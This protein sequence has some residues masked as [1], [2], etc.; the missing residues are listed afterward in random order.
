MRYPAQWD[1]LPLLATRAKYVH[2]HGLCIAPIQS[3]GRREGRLQVVKSAIIHLG[4]VTPISKKENEKNE[5]DRAREGNRG[6]ACDLVE[7]SKQPRARLLEE[8]L[9]RVYRKKRAPLFT[10]SRVHAGLFLEGVVYGLITWREYPVSFFDPATISRGVF[11]VWMFPT[12]Q[13]Q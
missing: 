1:G 12:S 10:C 2:R 3:R 4:A 6:R 5:R 7:Q 8:I 13:N 11:D 9:F